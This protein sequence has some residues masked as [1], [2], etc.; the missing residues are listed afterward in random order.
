[1]PEP[2][3]REREE[4]A[5][6]GEPHEHLRDRQRDE[7][8]VGD[9]GRTARP[10]PLGQEIVH[11]HVKCR[12]EGVEVGVHEASLVD[13]A[14]ATPPFGVLVMSPSTELPT[15]NSESTI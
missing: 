14:S 11:A 15:R 4:L 5:V 8:R 12:D 3:L 9:P 13:V 2:V 7:L 10:H 6:V 1:M